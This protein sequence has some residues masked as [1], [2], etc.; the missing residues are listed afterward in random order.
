VANSARL[1]LDEHPSYTRLRNLAVR[2]T[3]RCL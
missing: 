3:S 2:T 1:H